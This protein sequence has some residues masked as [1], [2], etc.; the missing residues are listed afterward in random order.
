[1]PPCLSA[2]L[3]KR[4]SLGGYIGGYGD[5]IAKLS[6]DFKDKWRIDSPPHKANIIDFA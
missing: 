3:P 5:K 1:M 6:N 2:I 4:F